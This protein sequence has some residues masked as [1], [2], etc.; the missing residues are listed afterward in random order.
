MEGTGP[1]VKE[2]RN[3][4]GFTKVGSSISANIFIRTA[5]EFKVEIEGQKNI[6]DLLKT[7]VVDGLLKIKF[8]PNVNV[9]SHKDM[10]IYISAPAFEEIKLSGSGDLKAG[11]TLTG[12]SLKLHLSGSGNVIIPDA[13]YADLQC[14]LSGSG[15][16]KL[17]GKAGSASMSISGSGNVNSS[18]LE[19]KSVTATISGSGDLACMATE[20]LDAKVSGSGNISYSG[21]PGAVKSRVSGSGEVKGK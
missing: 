17:G 15:D 10:N 3:V 11:N 4:S 1:V 13:Q 7:E 18:G 19:A 5:S 14:H 6:L 2:Q 9:N 12:Q 21:H 16:I 20:S 8:E